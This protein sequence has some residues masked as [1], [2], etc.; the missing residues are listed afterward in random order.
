M[1]KFAG[2]CLKKRQPICAAVRYSQADSFKIAF[3]SVRDSNERAG[4]IGNLKS[5]C[6]VVPLKSISK[7]MSVSS[8]LQLHEA[9][10]NIIAVAKGHL[11]YRVDHVLEY[12]WRVASGEFVRI[13]FG[14]IPKK[15]HA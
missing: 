1:C 6:K 7:Y 14:Q 12:V 9:R 13:K 4:A 11:R 8:S 15:L 5:V 2:G 3:K 10:G